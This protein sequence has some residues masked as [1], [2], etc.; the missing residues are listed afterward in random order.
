MLCKLYNPKRRRK[1]QNVKQEKTSYV[2]NN[3]KETQVWKK[4]AKCSTQ[5]MSSGA[6]QQEV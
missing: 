4:V 6:E 2:E 5:R 3:G 1:R